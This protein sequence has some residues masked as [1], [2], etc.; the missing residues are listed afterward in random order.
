MPPEH[1]TDSGCSTSPQLASPMRELQAS[2]QLKIQC[3]A[4]KLATAQPVQ[5]ARRVEPISPP[6]MQRQC[7]APHH[8]LCALRCLLD[9]QPTTC[10]AH[11]HPRARADRQLI[12][13][14]HAL[15]QRKEPSFDP[16]FDA[17]ERRVQSLGDVAKRNSIMLAYLDGC[18]H[19]EIATRLNAPLGSVKAWIKRGLLSLR[20][21]MA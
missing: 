17:A 19:S 11:I 6:T 21:C 13:S 10:R 8:S 16:R 20:E 12:R 2:P 7:A 3:A 14:C 9:S 5:P 1:A 4:T 18:S 15:P